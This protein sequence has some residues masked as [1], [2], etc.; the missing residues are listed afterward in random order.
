LG[1]A[2]VSPFSRVIHKQE[3]IQIDFLPDESRRR[4]AMRIMIHYIF[5]A[6][7]LGFYGGEV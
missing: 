1:C 2:I 4:T 7:A 3:T 5:A 6:L